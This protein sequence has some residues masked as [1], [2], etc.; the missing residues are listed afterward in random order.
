M[1]QRRPANYRC[2]ASRQI[3][4][5]GLSTE[6]FIEHLPQQ[7]RSETDTGDQLGP[8]QCTRLSTSEPPVPENSCQ[9]TCVINCAFRF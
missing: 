8:H 9:A 7:S 4:G 6:T 3:W 1:L 5:A 2:G